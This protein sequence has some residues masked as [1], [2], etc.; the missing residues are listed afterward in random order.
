MPVP[1]VGFQDLKKRVDAQNS[2]ALRQRSRLAELSQR[3]SALQQKHGLSNSVRASAAA[4]RQAQLHHLLLRLVRKVHL[5]IPAL[6]GQS[7]TPDEE[8]LRALLESCEAELSGAGASA[9]A[10]AG[11]AAYAGRLR[12]KVNELWAQLGVVRAKREMAEREGRSSGVEWAVVD[13][14]GLDNVAKVRNAH[15]FLLFVPSASVNSLFSCLLLQPVHWTDPLVAAARPQSS[16]SNAHARYQSARSSDAR[17]AGC[18]ACWGTELLI[19][20]CCCCCFYAITSPFAAIAL[21]DSSRLRFEA[22]RFPCGLALSIAYQHSTANHA[23]AFPAE[24]LRA[25]ARI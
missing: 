2:E 8:R 4:S 19:G 25:K 3:V 18:P 11:S 21:S 14:T 7:I 23:Y 15:T 1:A 13:E 10:G 17:I 22:Y 24:R 12:A 6:R 9:V 5:L 16:F 20:S